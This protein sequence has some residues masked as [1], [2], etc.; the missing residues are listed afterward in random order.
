MFSNGASNAT[1][2][3]SMSIYQRVLGDDFGALDPR[4]RRYFGPIPEGCVGV[5]SGRYRVAGLRVRALRPL[6]AVLGWR[7][8]AFAEYGADVPFTVRNIAHPDGALSAVRIFD[9]AT[10]TRTMRDAMQ[11]D[12]GR[13]VDRIGARGEIEVELSMRVSGGRLRMQSERLAVRLFGLRVPLPPLV[14]VLLTEQALPAGVQHVDVRMLAPLI[15]EIYGYSGDFTY[16][17]RRNAVSPEVPE[18]R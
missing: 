11:V 15:G 17:V 9:F 5:G 4:L 10:R 12:G 7:G 8:I 14:K 3:P 1:D 16:E 2:V 6:F 13:L 18:A